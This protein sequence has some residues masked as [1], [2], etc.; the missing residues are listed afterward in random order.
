MPNPVKA[1]P[2]ERR[3]KTKVRARRRTKPIIDQFDASGNPMPLSR[4]QR[5]VTKASNTGPYKR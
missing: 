3:M 2:E 4:Y 1:K 5:L